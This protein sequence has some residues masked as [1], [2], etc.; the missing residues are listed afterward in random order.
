MKENLS[1]VVEMTKLTK[2]YVAMQM[3]QKLKKDSRKIFEKITANHI[4]YLPRL[5]SEEI[6]NDYPE[7]LP[8][9]L[10]WPAKSL[11]PVDKKPA[12]KQ[13][14]LAEIEAEGLTGN[15]PRDRR[16]RTRYTGTYNVESL[17][18]STVKAAAEQQQR[19]RRKKTNSFSSECS[20]IIIASPKVATELPQPSRR[21]KT[22]SETS[23]GSSMVCSGSTVAPLKMKISTRRIQSISSSSSEGGSPVKDSPL[24]GF[25]SN[26]EPSHQESSSSSSSSGSSSD[27]SDEEI[28][29]KKKK[30]KKEVNTPKKSGL[31][32]PKLMK[33]SRKQALNIP[34]VVN[35]IP[36]PFVK[37]I[38]K[39][40]IQEEVSFLLHLHL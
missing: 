27:S 12:I 34:K 7:D 29:K 22:I 8:N 4:S 37:E 19:P 11:F 9:Y 21:K 2:N 38:P 10:M 6:N 36:K 28:T 32:E 25:K 13:E 23:D 18:A 39:K 1:P 3:D 40:P 14:I 5:Q 17:T 15:T 33:H 24:K 26:G 20:S 31:K 30:N 16:G 35:S